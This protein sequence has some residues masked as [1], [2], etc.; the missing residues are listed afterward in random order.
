MGNIILFAC[1]ERNQVQQ[2]IYKAHAGLLL[3][4]S[5]PY[6]ILYAYFYTENKTLMRLPIGRLLACQPV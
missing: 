6:A 2:F 1:K 3:H 4:S 5:I